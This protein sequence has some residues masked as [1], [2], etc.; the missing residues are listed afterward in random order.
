ME[1]L[2]THIKRFIIPYIIVLA[3]LILLYTALFSG[4]GNISQSNDFLFGALS[5]LLLGIVIILILRN[6]IQKNYF[7]FIIPVM[8]FY[9]LFLS[10]KTY[11][12][13]ATTIDQIELKKEINAHVKQ[14]LRDIEV[15]QIE[16][17]KK[18]GWYAN[19]FEELKR[20]LIE[21][22]VYSVS[23]I[24]TVPDYKITPEHQ[25]ILGYDPVR[26]YIQIESYDEK[27]ALLCGLLAKDTSWQN[28]RDKLFPTSSDSSKKRL[29][30]FVIDHL[31]R[32]NLTHDGSNKLFVMDSDILETSD[33]NTFECL[34][35]K[36]GTNFHFVTANI[37]DFNQNDTAYYDLEINGLIVKDSIPQI[38]SLLIGDILESA[39]NTK[40][41]SPRE[42]YNLIKETRKDT[43]TFKVIRNNQP[44]IILLTQ[45]DIVPK[46]SKINWSDLED[47]LNYNLLPP[48]YNP[49]GFEK[50]YIGK[51]LVIKEDE[52]SSPSLD[53][54]KF[55]T[56]LENRGFDTTSLSFEYNRDETFSFSDLASSDKAIY[57]YTKIGTPVFQAQDPSPYDPLLERDTLITGSMSEVKTSGN[58]K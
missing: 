23:T 30:D 16:Y 53:L 10:Y 2:S 20:F 4:T 47:M 48:Y 43:I 35:Y 41:K 37:I 57:L 9:C 28:V 25:E 49:I 5:V 17:K 32:V 45:K 7:K 31:N 33:E 40:I 8:I 55:K 3:G 29:Y 6:V 36:S 51:D 58:W 42:I 27:E 19:K 11:N 56:L 34:L 15:V 39:N 21:D 38:P 22:S 18:Y 52:F 46:P 13:I 26:D 14:G 1:R 44:Q 50:M 12:S 54:S 24:G